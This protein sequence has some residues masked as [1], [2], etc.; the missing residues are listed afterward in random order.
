LTTGWNITITWT[1]F[2]ADAAERDTRIRHL[3]P[4]LATS[5]LFFSNAL[6]TKPLIEGFV[7]YGM[8][9]DDGLP[10][11]VAR[12]ADHLP[13]SVAAEELDEEDLAWEMMMQRDKYNLIYGRGAYS[14]PEPEPEELEPNSSFEE[15][16]YNDQGLEV[17]MP[18]LE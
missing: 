18:G 7:Q 1:E 13:V 5:R 16:A 12:V 11:V 15:R 17:I 9:P 14:P 10:D 2:E 3:E 8:S 4:L 6:K